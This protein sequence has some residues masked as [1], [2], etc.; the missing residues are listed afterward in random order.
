MLNFP[1]FKEKKIVYLA[2]YDEIP[3]SLRFHNSNIRLYK[4]DKFINQISCFLVHVIIIFGHTTISSYLIRKLMGYGISILFIDDS[5][6]FYAGILPNAEGNTYL[7]EIQ[8]KM[9]K[10]KIF[11]ISKNLIKLKVKNQYKLIKIVGGNLEVKNLY[12][13][14]IKNIDEANESKSILGL[15]GNF[16]A[17]YF[18]IVFKSIGWFRRAPRTKEDIPNLLLDIGYTFLFNYVDSLLRLF[19]FDTYKG[20]YHKLFFQRKSLSCDLME[21]LRV[22]VDRQLIK[23]YHLQQIDLDDFKFV[24]SCFKFKNYKISKKY[25]HIWF[26]MIW[27]NREEIYKFLHGFYRYMCLKDAKNF[28]KFLI[29]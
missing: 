27:M 11:E 22:L 20:I 1:D 5:F 13:S 14:T 9:Q 25:L 6:R 8:Y 19:G 7:R 17:N 15:E 18:K 28:P 3:N 4:N 24:N 21:P 12:K 23:S 16:S 26:K 2:N 10:D 29:K